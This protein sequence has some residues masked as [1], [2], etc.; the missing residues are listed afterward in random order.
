[1]LDWPLVSAMPW[2][3]RRAALEA[4]VREYLSARLRI[5]IPMQTMAL[6]AAIYPR[7]DKKTQSYIASELTKLA[8]Y[9]APYATHDGEQFTFAGKLCTRWQWRGSLEEFT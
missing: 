4:A 7:G 6:A 8:P 3:P 5:D 9:L 2:R 1:M